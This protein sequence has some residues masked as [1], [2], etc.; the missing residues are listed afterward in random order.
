MAY[1]TFLGTITQLGYCS[2][3]EHSLLHYIS[4]AG[5]EDG[6]LETAIFVVPTTMLP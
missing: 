5:P 2:S 3:L 1:G 6:A 4:I